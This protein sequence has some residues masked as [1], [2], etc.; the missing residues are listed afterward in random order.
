MCSLL[1]WRDPYPKQRPESVLRASG[2]AALHP[3]TYADFHDTSFLFRCYRLFRQ[4]LRHY[5]RWA[6]GSG[7]ALRHV[8][9]QYAPEGAVAGRL[10]LLL[11]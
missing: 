7:R 10:L 8:L 5:D 11:S 6:A 9:H 3:A 2:V 4:I 1:D